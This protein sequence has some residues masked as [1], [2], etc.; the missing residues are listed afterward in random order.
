MRRSRGCA[1]SEFSRSKIPAFFEK[2]N[3]SSAKEAHGEEHDDG[4]EHAEER[5]RRAPEPC[6]RRPRHVRA[7]EEPEKDD[8]GQ[9]DRVL[10]HEHRRLEKRE[11]QQVR[12]DAKAL[13]GRRAVERERR[14]H[15]EE[16]RQQLG[17]PHERGHGL[18]VN[19]RHRE[20]R[21]RRHA[22]PARKA[23][24]E[25]PHREEHGDPAVERDVHDAERPGA[26]PVDPFL[27]GVRHEDER[28]V[29]RARG[30]Q[31]AEVVRRE[32]LGKHPGQKRGAGCL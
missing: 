22:R 31:P 14:G 21:G 23:E 29:G 9:D 12:S 17:P 18:H 25:K 6:E 32:D 5:Q 30:E 19:G 16:R 2:R 10:L 13:G 26:V 7:E 24:R 8:A 11:T 3:P 15:H 27:D 20:E 28:A 4:T 1:T